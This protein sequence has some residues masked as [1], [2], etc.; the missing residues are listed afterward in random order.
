MVLFCQTKKKPDSI[1]IGRCIFCIN[2]KVYFLNKKKD[3]N[4]RLKPHFVWLF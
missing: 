2:Y 3:A 4:S 1:M